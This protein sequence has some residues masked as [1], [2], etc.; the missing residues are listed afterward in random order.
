M[1]VWF[2]RLSIRICFVIRHSCFVILIG[3]GILFDLTS[4]ARDEFRKTER[5]V[6]PATLCFDFAIACGS[7]GTLARRIRAAMFA[8][9]HQ[10][11]R[12]QRGLRLLRTERPLHYRRRT[13]RFASAGADPID[14]ETSAGT[15]ATRFCMGAAWR[16]VRDGTD[17]LE[18]VL[19]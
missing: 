11:R 2:R 8:A 19:E 13:R 9:Q 16:G 3:L 7:S 6:S 1:R 12:L 18:R 14:R 15:R 17:K 5:A 4:Q 10:D